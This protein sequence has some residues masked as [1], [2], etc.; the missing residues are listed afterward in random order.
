M[1]LL[2]IY[3]HKAVVLKERTTNNV[4]QNNALVNRGAFLLQF[5]YTR[6]K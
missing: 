4:F 2:D 3:R 6:L 1:E 5:V